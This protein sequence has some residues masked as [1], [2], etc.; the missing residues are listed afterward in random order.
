M[1]KRGGVDPGDHSGGSDKN[2]EFNPHLHS[3]H[4]GNYWD[5]IK[6]QMGGKNEAG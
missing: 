5:T 6:K 3:A 2:D 1:S 4:G